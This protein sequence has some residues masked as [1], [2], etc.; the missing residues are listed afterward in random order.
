MYSQNP[1]IHPI[2]FACV[3]VCFVFRA[4]LCLLDVCLLLRLLVVVCCFVF[5]VCLCLLDVCL[6]LRLLVFVL[7]AFRVCLQI[8]VFDGWLQIT[9]S[10]VIA[11][12]RCL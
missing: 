11:C 4:C 2:A 10:N 5:R 9:V 1:K 7:F 3:C 6:I 12:G 8:H